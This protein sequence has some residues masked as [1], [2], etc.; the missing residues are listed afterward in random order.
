MIYSKLSFKLP[1]LDVE[2]GFEI[3]LLLRNW[4]VTTKM[5]CYYKIDLLLSQWLQYSTVAGSHPNEVKR[6]FG[7]R[8]LLQRHHVPGLALCISRKSH[9]IYCINQYFAA[10]QITWFSWRDQKS[11]LHLFTVATAVAIHV[12]QIWEAP[13]KRRGTGI[14][15]T[16]PCWWFVMLIR[17]IG[18]A[19][20]A[21]FDVFGSLGEWLSTS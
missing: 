11:L 21:S 12:W 4:S 19:T 15:A 7:S 9:E 20:L 10:L 6:A 18:R 13:S 5:I 16:T 17:L 1:V 14:A 3:D 8:E 2:S